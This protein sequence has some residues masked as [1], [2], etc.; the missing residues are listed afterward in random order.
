[1]AAH[2][3]EKEDDAKKWQVK[4]VALPAHAPPATLT[5]ASPKVL[6]LPSS[7]SS[8]PYITLLP[9]ESGD[10]AIA[11]GD[12]KSVLVEHAQLPEPGVCSEC[13]QNKANIQCILKVCQKCCV[14]SINSEC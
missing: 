3:K 1:V 2:E 11:G 9:E 12:S 7:T 8:T 14:W 4:V 5:A 10:V 13:K 6:S